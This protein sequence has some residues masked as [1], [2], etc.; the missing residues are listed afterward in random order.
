MTLGSH[1]PEA[2]LPEIL[3]QTGFRNQLDGAL[4]FLSDAPRASGPNAHAAK[5]S[6]SAKPVSPQDASLFGDGR[7]I[8]VVEI[9]GM[10]SNLAKSG[11]LWVTTARERFLFQ[12]ED[13]RIVYAQSDRPPPGCRLGEM[14]IERGALDAHDLAEALADARQNGQPLGAWLLAANLVATSDLHAALRDQVQQI[15]NRMFAAPGSTYQFEEGKRLGRADDVRMNVVQLLLE[16]ARMQ[17]ERVQLPFPIG[18][19]R[20]GCTAT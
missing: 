4:D 13:G 15:F 8:L 20:E 1:E 3:T 7:S 6:F 16:S 14:L 5:S 10:L 11:L 18:A 12:L 2:P 9:I 17:D 19:A